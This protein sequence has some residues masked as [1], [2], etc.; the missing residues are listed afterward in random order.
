VLAAGNF[1]ETAWQA[2]KAA[3]PPGGLSYFVVF[4]GS[5]DGTAWWHYSTRQA[6]LGK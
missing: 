5:R 3:R 2:F 1:P 6:T 4:L